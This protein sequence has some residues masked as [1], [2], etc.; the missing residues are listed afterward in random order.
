MK[1]EALKLAL[2]DLIA[3]YHMQYSSF[4]R[5]VDDIFKEALVA[6]EDSSVVRSEEYKGAVEVSIIF[7]EGQKMFAVPKQPAP[8]Q[9]PVTDETVEAYCKAWGESF[10]RENKFDVLEPLSDDLKKHIRYGLKKAFAATGKQ[11]LQ[12]ATPPA[13]PASCPHGMVDTCCENPGNCNLSAAKP[14]PVQPVAH[15]TVRPLRGD[16]S[17]PKTEIIWVKGKPIAG[18]LYT[19]PPAQPAPVQPVAWVDLLKQAEE[20]VRSKSLWKKY[21]DGTPLANDIAVWMA[22]FAQESTAAQPA[23]VQQTCNCR[24]DGEVQVQQCT[25]HQAHVDAIHEWAERAKSAEAKLVAQP[26]PDLQAE[27]DATNRQVEILS[28]ALAESRRE[29]AALKAVQEPVGYEYHEYRPYGAPGEIHINA[30]LKSRYTMPDGSTA[31][32]YQW[33]IDQYRANQNTIKLIP[34]YATPATQEIVCS[35]GLCHYKAVPDAMFRH[36]PEHPQYVEGWNDCRAQMLRGRNACP[37][38]NNDCNQ[39]RNC[40]A[41]KNT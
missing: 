28:D 30:I 23:P 17:F 3:E 1:D 31:G 8:V 7:H 26:A 41:R 32:D 2:D 21:I 34:L 25:L 15:C 18:P 13:Q 11:S 9:E 20:V 4:A 36:A 6:P 10:S 24:W 39:G 22:K 16:E 27:L 35:T 14:A 12:V 5:R 33:L 38:C 37:P 40:P 19:T 29:V